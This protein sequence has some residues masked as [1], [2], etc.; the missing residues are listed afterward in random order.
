MA[1]NHEPELEVVDWSCSHG[2][3]EQHGLHRPGVSDLEQVHCMFAPVWGQL[4]QQN[5]TR[6]NLGAM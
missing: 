4:L 5:E 1:V 2:P 6:S 3:T